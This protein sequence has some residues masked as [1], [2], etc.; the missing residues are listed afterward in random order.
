MAE[1]I[2]SDMVKKTGLEDKISVSSSATSS[3]EIYRGIGN[4]IYPPALSELKKH[5]I[6]TYDHRATKL[7][8]S[9]Y[10]SIIGTCNFCKSWCALLN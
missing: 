8:K 5:N 2:F 9:D 6:P 4:P 3:E 7:L 10:V 1:A